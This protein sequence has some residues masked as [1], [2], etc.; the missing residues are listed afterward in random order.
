MYRAAP[1]IHPACDTAALPMTDIRDS[2]VHPTLLALLLLGIGL[3]MIVDIIDDL[4]YATSAAHLVMESAIVLLAAWGF[5]ALWRQ[6]LEAR[7]EARALGEH[8]SA[9]RAERDRWRVEAQDALADLSSAI[10]RQF[11]RWELT[12]AERGIALLLLRGLSHKEIAGERTTSERTVRQ[13]ALSIYRKAGVHSRGE[14]AAF[15]LRDLPENST[16]VAGGR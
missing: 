14:L 2:D 16:Q 9:A 4:R 10:E 12:E 6:A 5:A 3:F 13:Q 15:F 7:R 11:E 1:P 8:L